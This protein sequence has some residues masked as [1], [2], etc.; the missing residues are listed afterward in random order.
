LFTRFNPKLSQ[1]KKQPMAKTRNNKILVG[2]DE[3]DAKPTRTKRKSKQVAGVNPPARTLRFLG[4]LEAQGEEITNLTE[5][6]MTIRTNKTEQLT[7][8][9]ISMY[10]AIAVTKAT[11]V[12]VDLSMYMIIEFL[13]NRLRRS[14]TD[15]LYITNEKQRQT[16]LLAELILSCV[17]GEWLNLSERE[18]LPEDV[19]KLIEDNDWL[20]SPRTLNSWKSH[21]SLEAMFAVKIVPVEYL[22]KRNP[23]SIAERYSGYTRG[24]GQEGNLP[25][26]GKTKP[27]PEL[28]GVDTDREPPSFTLLELEK[29]NDILISIE[30]YKATKRNK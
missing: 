24:Y 14:G 3:A 17:R 23:K 10:L 21:W 25:A 15:P 13:Y 29:Y 16:V 8:R 28:D 19:V 2:T 11:L 9:E 4:Y 5:F 12:G 1:E 18:Q 20:P 22:I 27:S 7:P 26:P 6:H 30:R